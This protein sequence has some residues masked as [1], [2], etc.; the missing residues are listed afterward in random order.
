MEKNKKESTEFRFYEKPCHEP[1]L[2][3][4]GKGWIRNYGEGVDQLHFHNMAEIGYCRHGKGQVIFNKESFNYNDNTVTFIAHNYPHTTDSDGYSQWEFLYFDAEEM[5]MNAFKDN[6]GKCQKVLKSI[7]EKAF[8][9]SGTEDPYIGNLVLMIFDLM[10]HKGSYYKETIQGA[11]F[12]ILMQI[13]RIDGDGFQTSGMDGANNITSS[14]EYISYHYREDIRI[15]DL[16]ECCHLSETH[17]RRVFQVYMSMTPVEYLN[18]TR[19][20]AACDLMRNG[21][22]HMEE[23]AINVGYQTMSTFNRNFK[24]ILGISPYQW[25]KQM[26]S[27]LSDLE[28]YHI[29]AKR[30]WQ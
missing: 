18:L 8:V 22:R 24:R 20:Q 1:V 6:I 3:L 27:Q 21:D 30:G 16:A 12:T 2:A 14:L 9:F 5:V 4:M 10:C 28:P 29:R 15:H 25:K 26:I 19:V 7:R 23:I 17:F 11:L 13:V